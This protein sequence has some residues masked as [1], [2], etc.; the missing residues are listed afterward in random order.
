L[1]IV[2]PFGYI[3]AGVV[4]AACVVFFFPEVQALLQK[5]L[6]LPAP[7]ASKT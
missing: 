7:S 6:N 2:P 3:A 4:F 5:W 1:A